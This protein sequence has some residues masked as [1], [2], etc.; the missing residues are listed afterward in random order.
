MNIYIDEVISNSQKSKDLD[1]GDK[2][3]GNVK[4]EI[5]LEKEFMQKI[6]WI[7]YLAS[8]TQKWINFETKKNI[9]EFKLL[10]SWVVRQFKNEYN[11]THFHD[12]HISGV[13]YLKVPSDF[14]N[15]SRKIRHLIE[16]VDLNVMD[17]G[18]FYVMQIIVST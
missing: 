1:Y 8:L 16:M 10:S 14:G 13:G 15:Y 11:P 2:L 3:A 12:G 9:S 5:I 17:Q 4:Q 6:K 7:E 18:C